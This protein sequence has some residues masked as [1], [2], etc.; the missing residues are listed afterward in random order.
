MLELKSM[1]LFSRIKNSPVLKR[2]TV[3]EATILITA[4]LFLSK[5]IGCFREILVAK[6]FGATSQTDA[7]VVA[8]IIPALIMGL[9]SSGLSTL[10]IPIYIEKRKKDVQKAKI[11]VNQIFFLW[12]AILLGTSLL[13]FFFTPIL[14][15]SVAFGFKGERLDLAITLTR[16]LIPIGFAT[17][18]IGFFTGL[19]QARKQFLYPTLIGVIGNILIIISLVFFRTKLGLNS[20]TFGQIL[21]AVFSFFAL[22]WVLRQNSFFHNFFLKYID[23]VEIKHFFILLFP[24]V[25]AS[26]IATLNQIIDKTIA[27]SLQIG[28]IAILDFAQKTFNI[29]LSLLVMPLVVAIFPTFSSLALEKNKEAD[30]AYTLKKAL[31]LSW[32]IIIPATF[33]LVVLCQPIVKLLFQ[34]GAF[35]AEATA[36]TAFTVSM[37]SLGLFA[38]AANYFLISVFYSFKN[39]KAPLII[40]AVIVAINILGNIILSRILGVAGIGLAT[41]IAAIVGFV[42]FLSILHK[43]YFK[44][45]ARRPLV[46]QVLKII[47]ASIPLATYS[48]F[49][50]SYL[51]ASLGLLHLLPR[52][53]LAGI[54]LVL[55]YLFLSYFLNLEGFNIIRGYVKNRIKVS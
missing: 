22:F 38:Y 27:S 12:C 44:T 5:I 24:L 34:R 41:A 25:L 46:S 7:F 32:Y 3:A 26:G 39:T 40:S 30:Y 36:I 4:L 15:K 23:W 43:R 35:S 55:L 50:K 9:F 47:L 54:S 53:I 52:F 16:Y 21:H 2:Q 29:P 8:L 45:S 11:F 33:I 13:I 42:L 14:V 18:C 48:F 17:V 31:S 1:S 28:S 51:S 20:W 19:F 6:Y 49:L 37:Y 10:I